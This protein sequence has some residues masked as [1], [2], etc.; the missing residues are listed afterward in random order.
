MPVRSSRPS[1]AARP[2]RA[3]IST[4]AAL[5]PATIRAQIQA[6]TESLVDAITSDSRFKGSSPPHP[7]LYQMWDF[8]MRTTYVLSELD[9]I[10]E[11]RPV[12][13]PEQVP[14]YVV[15]SGR[16]SP[17]K[18]KEHMNDVLT[19]SITIYLMIKPATTKILLDQMGL[20]V[21]EFGSEIQAKAEAL[22]EI[23]KALSPNIM[24]QFPP[25]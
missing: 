4:G 8:A 9:N 3:S 11:G 1:R 15:A 2:R 19:R 5:P 21:I 14:D 20:P 17:E 10:S 18:A 25:L 6:A 16:P 23:V 12:K 7:T 13:F 24:D 22:A